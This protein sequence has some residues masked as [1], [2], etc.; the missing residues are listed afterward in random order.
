M[1]AD[2]LRIDKWLWQARFFKTR[3]LAAT[4]VKSGK[5]RL[6]EVSTSKAHQ[7]VR[8][9]DVLTFPA[10][11]YI[12][13]IKI[14]ELGTRRGPATEAQGLFE[15]LHPISEQ[16]KPPQ[17]QGAS[18]GRDRGAGRPTKADRRAIEKFKGRD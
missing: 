6:N 13:V 16:P 18:D 3:A 11:P 1:A 12:R 17:R 7:I 9:G 14:V 10:G 2:G 15:D 8:P 5:L 4:F